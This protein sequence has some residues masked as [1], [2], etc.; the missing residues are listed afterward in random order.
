MNFIKKKAIIP[1]EMNIPILVYLFWIMRT[2][3][4]GTLKIKIP[5]KSKSEN[6][7]TRNGTMGG[8]VEESRSCA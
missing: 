3:K 4:P 7:K 5:G 6:R 2:N 1:L 8:D